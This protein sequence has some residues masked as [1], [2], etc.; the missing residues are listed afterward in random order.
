MIV[1]ATSEFLDQVGY[2]QLPNV[3][4]VHTAGCDRK[5]R[6]E[7]AGGRFSQALSPPHGLLGPAW[8]KRSGHDRPGF[9]ELAISILD[10][11][12]LIE[13]Y[14]IGLDA[15]RL[16]DLIGGNLLERRRTG[17]G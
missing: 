8:G 4:G 9:D 7:C 17:G 2:D 5:R 12:R 13:P 14:G 6:L 10:L 1:E 11:H 15:G 16:S 3:A